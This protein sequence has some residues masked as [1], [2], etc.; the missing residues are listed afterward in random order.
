MPRVKVPWCAPLSRSACRL[1]PAFQAV[2]SMGRGWLRRLRA[3]GPRAG[4]EAGV[5]SR[6]ATVPAGGRRSGATLPVP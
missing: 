5:P 6:H 3:R 2:S 1:K 4:L